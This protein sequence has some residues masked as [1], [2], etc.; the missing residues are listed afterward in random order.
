MLIISIKLKGV[1]LIRTQLRMADNL[2]LD[3]RVLVL[4]RTQK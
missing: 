4:L 1:E 2:Y 3:Q